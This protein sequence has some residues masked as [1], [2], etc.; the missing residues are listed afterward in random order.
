M[1]PFVMYSGVIRD[2]ETIMQNILALTWFNAL[3]KWLKDL[4]KGQKGHLGLN[5]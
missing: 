3:R 4:F 5:D 1:W 2:L